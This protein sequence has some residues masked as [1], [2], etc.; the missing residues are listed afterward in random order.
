VAGFVSFF[1]LKYDVGTKLYITSIACI[2]GL[3][4]IIIAEWRDPGND[5][6]ISDKND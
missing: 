6:A 3:I 4:L 2:L 5:V 1:A